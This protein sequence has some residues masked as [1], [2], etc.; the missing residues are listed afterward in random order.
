MNNIAG[1]QLAPA[2]AG[3]GEQGAKTTIDIDAVVALGGTGMHGQSVEFF[4]VLLEVQGHGLQGQGALLEIHRHQVLAANLAAILNGVL[5]IEG[6][7]VGVGDD[8]AIDG[9]GQGLGG[10]FADPLAGNETFQD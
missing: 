10:L 2:H 3:I 8:L 5:E 4:L 6:V 7:V 1:R 9:A